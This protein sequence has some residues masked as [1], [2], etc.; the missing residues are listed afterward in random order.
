MGNDTELI[1]LREE[2]KT[3][4]YFKLKGDKINKYI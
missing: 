1:K 4:K 2:V 3:K